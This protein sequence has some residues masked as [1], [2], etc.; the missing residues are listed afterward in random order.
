MAFNYRIPA[1]VPATDLEVLARL[2]SDPKGAAALFDK[3]RVAR[4]EYEALRASVAAEMDV[5]AKRQADVDSNEL[6]FAAEFKAF[7]GAKE[8]FAAEKAA[9]TKQRSAVED[10][11]SKREAELADKAVALEA[12]NVQLEADFAKLA[13]DRKALDGISKQTFNELHSYEA[14]LEAREAAVAARE[15]KAN[16]L[17]ALL[18]EV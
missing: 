5:L 12:K 1:P 17:A 16:K 6:D 18:R 13:E 14:Q 11:L 8:Q 2:I 7:L 10:A 15:E 4:E 9:W 3:Y